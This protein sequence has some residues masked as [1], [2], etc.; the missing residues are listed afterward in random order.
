M[1]SGDLVGGGLT[2]GPGGVFVVGDVVGEASVEDADE[3]ASAIFHEWVDEALSARIGNNLVLSFILL[4]QMGS[5]V[6]LA[7]LLFNGRRRI[8]GPAAIGM[9]AGL[10]TLLAWAIRA[11]LIWVAYEYTGVGPVAKY[12]TYGLN[13]ITSTE[14]VEVSPLAYLIL[15]IPALVLLGLSFLASRARNENQS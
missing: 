15:A 14:A 6:F 9:I 7:I 3:D 1:S 2:V 11:R 5:L 8:L 12:S 13:L 4:G 10:G